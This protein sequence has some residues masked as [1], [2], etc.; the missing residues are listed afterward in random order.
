VGFT[1]LRQRRQ[2]SAEKDEPKS[3]YFF[4]QEP[5][6]IPIFMIAVTLYPLGYQNNNLLTLWLYQGVSS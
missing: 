5:Q 3:F 2:I 4:E 6:N 1:R